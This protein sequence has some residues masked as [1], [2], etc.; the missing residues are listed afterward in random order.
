M[1]AI[2]GQEGIFVD[3]DTGVLR[4]DRLLIQSG[5]GAVYFF[6]LGPQAE[7]LRRF[8]CDEEV[9]EEPLGRFLSRC[10][11]VDSVIE[12]GQAQ[13]MELG[14][15]RWLV[16][17]KDRLLRRIA[18]AET[19]AKA[20]F[21]PDEPRDESGRWTIAGGVQSSTVATPPAPQQPK[22]ADDR[23]AT[24]DIATRD[25]RQ[26]AYQALPAPMTSGDVAAFSGS[27]LKFWFRLF[28]P[29]VL[30]RLV[31]LASRLTAPTAFFGIILIPTNRNLRGGGTL[32]NRPDISYFY[33]TPAGIFNLSQDD[34]PFFEGH[35]I[36]N[37][38]FRDDDGRIMARDIGGT[39]VVDYDALPPAQAPEPTEPR[40]LVGPP[41]APRA[42]DDDERRKVCP[43]PERDVGRKMPTEAQR[44]PPYVFKDEADLY[45]SYVSGLPPGLAVKLRN[46]KT[47]RNVFYD[48]C[49]DPDRTMLD[50]KYGYLD[51]LPNKSRFLWAKQSGKWIR[52]GQ[53]QLDAA[54]GRWQVE[55]HFSEEAV[56]D[57]VRALFADDPSLRRIKIVYDPLPFELHEEDWEKLLRGGFF[58]LSSWAD[59]PSLL[60]KSV[61]LIFN[62]R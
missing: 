23:S 3:I 14:L 36:G 24:T 33:D 43:D 20:G 34:E 7:Q 47:L 26:S 13:A 55:W 19:L 30:R 54:D 11:V 38:I 51:V 17:M 8:V 50:A 41:P 53:R 49:R 60:S 45:Q 6:G 37:G 9:L 29:A 59:W 32:P 5:H 1:P 48:G 12:A 15:P 61:R 46:P 39:L 18:I 56:A 25:V 21:D 35:T 57:A 42:E 10:L 52:Q 62:S 4:R 22:Q 27:E 44:K 58:R 16:G 2:A 31:L 28:V 40:P